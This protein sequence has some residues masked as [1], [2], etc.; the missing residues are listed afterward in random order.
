MRVLLL[1]YE[2][3]PCGSGAGLTTEALAE[4]LAAR[5]VTVDVVAGGDHAS[6][7]PRLFWDGE[8]DDGGHAHGAPG[9]EPPARGPRGRGPR[10]DGLPLGGHAGGAAPA[11]AR[12]VRRGALRLLASHRGHAAAAR[13]ARR[14]G[15]RLAAWLGRARVRRRAARRA[16]RAPAAPPAHPLDLA[17]RR[18][19]GGAL[20]EPGPARAADRR[21]GSGTRWCMAAWN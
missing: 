15:D 19:C 3:P 8:A 7:D 14:A 21:R 11:R 4:G 13:P 5:G 16:A 1:N 17:S 6:S 12:A 18:S 20:R 2:Y 10:R 9:L